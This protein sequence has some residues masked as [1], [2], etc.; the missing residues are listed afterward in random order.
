MNEKYDIAFDASFLPTTGGFGTHTYQSLQNFI[1][2][3]SQR[4]YLLL[5]NELP[6]VIPQYQ[7]QEAHQQ[8]RRLEIPAHW[9][10]EKTRRRSRVAWMLYD[11]PRQIQ[12]YKPRLF[13]SID[14]VTVPARSDV[15]QTVVILHDMIPI[16]HPRYCRRRDALAARWLF[17]RAVRHADKII[18]VSNFSA[19]E[20]VRC[21]PRAESKI[22]VIQNGVDHDKLHP[23]P[24]RE[25]AAERIAAKYRLYS[26]RYWL[27]VTT[28]SPRRNLQRFLRAYARH[29]NDSNDRETCLVVAGCRGWKDQDIFQT[30][31]ELG[32]QSRVHFLDFVPDQDLHGLF[33]TAFALAN[34][35][36][37]EGFGLTVLEAMACGT[38]VLCS[39]TTALGEVAG[40]AAFTVD[41]LSVE[42]MADAITAIVSGDDIR[43]DLSRKGIDHARRFRWDETTK[44]VIALFDSMLK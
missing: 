2:F 23:I 7:N 25:S 24:D 1:R 15:C 22:V 17:G 31:D 34:P 36:L 9:R 12:K 37:L 19:G 32:I 27:I 18:T 16:S 40:D 41:P 6:P 26:P 30:L 4:S 8:A 42:S 43:R 14:N 3:D 33:Q 11:L 20:I 39:S 21:F 38:P 28:L 35:S 5:E 13:H 10:W 29:L 44:R